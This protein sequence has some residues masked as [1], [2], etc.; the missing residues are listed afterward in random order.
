MEIATDF[1]CELR[2]VGLPVA[3]VILIMALI[4]H[5]GVNQLVMLSGLD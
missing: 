5:D 1:F 3:F 4:F 2:E